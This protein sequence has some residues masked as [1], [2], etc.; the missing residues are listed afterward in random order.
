LQI[1]TPSD[2]EIMM[3]RVFDAPRRLVFDAYT[4]PELLKRWLGVHNGWVLAVCEID[5]RP[6]GTYRYVWRGPN[7]ED[8][9]MRGV[10]QEVVVPERLVTTEEFDQKWYEGECRGT[11][12]FTERDGKTTLAMRLLYDSRAIRD[13]V[14]KS[15]MEQGIKAGFDTLAQVLTTM[16]AQ[17]ITTFLW[18]DGNAE[19]AMKFYVSIFKNSKVVSTMPGPDGKVLT[20]TFELEGQRFMALNGG[21]QFKFTEAISL[22]VNCETQS[23]VDDLWKKLIAGGGAESQ[24]GWLKDKFGLS[25]QIIPSALGRLLG[26]RDRA[27]AGRAMQAMLQMRKIDIAKLQQAFDGR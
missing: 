19:E 17:K 24:C 10:F 14:L 18:F 25:W 5:L 13:A 1:T 9:G 3:T 26:D 2:R 21:P 7:R 8:M 15:P 6:G 20:G 22:F 11:V 12:T 27:K 16:K 4:K 23:E